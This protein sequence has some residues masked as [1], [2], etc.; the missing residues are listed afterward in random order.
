VPDLYGDGA[1]TA[2]V[3]E[4]EALA[5]RVL[6]EGDALTERLLEVRRG[7]A[8]PVAVVG[9]SLG[10]TTALRLLAADPTLRAAVLY[11]GTGE[12]PAVARVPVLGHFADQDPF[13]P[14]EWVRTFEQQLKDAGARPEFHVY[15]GAHHWF[16][17]PGRPEHDA[18]AAD[19]AW[20]RTVEFLRRELG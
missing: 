17:E 10:A 20:T 19:L 1:T 11:Y 12:V 9:F 2:D 15:D 3:D 13:E 5:Q 16:A 18:A 4:A 6:G 8:D 7:L 14:M